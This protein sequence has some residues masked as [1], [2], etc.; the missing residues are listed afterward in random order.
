MPSS[1]MVGAST[2]ER[3]DNLMS[4]LTHVPDPC[5]PRG[6]DYPL[7][8]ILAVAVCAV[9]TGAR[10]FTAIGEWALDLD[11]AHQTGNGPVFGTD[12]N[13]DDGYF[14]TGQTFTLSAGFD[15]LASIE[16]ITG[17]VVTVAGEGLWAIT[18]NPG[19]FEVLIRFRTTVTGPYTL[20]SNGPVDNSWNS[21]GNVLPAA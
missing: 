19:V 5:D 16:A 7:G 3:A 17:G 14:P 9:L 21:T 4:A 6:I 13:G 15:F 1:P 2:I 11:A 8:G 10:S 20:S 18:P 12:D